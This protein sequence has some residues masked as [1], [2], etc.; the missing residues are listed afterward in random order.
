MELGV[1]RSFVDLLDRHVAGQKLPDDEIAAIVQARDA[2]RNGIELRAASGRAE[3]EDQDA[4]YHLGN[5]AVV[6]VRGVIAPHA[7]MVNGMSQPRGIDCATL[8]D[9]LDAAAASSAR[10]ILLHV[11]SPGG[12]VAGMSDLVAKVAEVN[13]AKPIVALANDTMASAAYWIGS[14][15]TEIYTTPTALV[16]SI[17]VYNVVEDTSEA[18]AKQGVKRFLVK[19]GKRKGGGAEGV[20]VEQEDLDEMEAVARSLRAVFIADVARGRGMSVESVTALAEGIVWVGH[21]AQATGLTDGVRLAADLV[22]EMQTRFAVGAHSLAAQINSS[23]AHLGRIVARTSNQGPH[24]MKLADLKEKYPEA[25]KEHEAEV[26]AKVA[27]ETK[28]EDKPE[29][30]PE[31]KAEDKPE[32]MP[33]D[34]EKEE[35]TAKASGP[36]ALDQLVAAFPGE[37][38]FWA[39]CLVGKLTLAQAHAERTKALTAQVSD[40]QK[41]LD[42]A[43]TNQPRFAG[44]GADPVRHAASSAKSTDQPTGYAATVRQIM[45]DDKVNVNIAMSRAARAQPAQHQAWIDAG[46]PV[47]A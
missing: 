26:R 13:R 27:E 20:K 36:A 6:P 8:A 3:G 5:V 2:K 41:Q 14:Q 11:D 31:G 43:T 10:S 18:Y 12:C 37:K 33:A 4:P 15:C 24:A 19:A 29:D 40:L 22:N 39:D 34:P 35:E 7:N 1:L 17:G 9:R 21:E 44:R 30:K 16:G 32:D 23:T 38:A 42:Q 46:C 25:M 47:I 45:V 28:P